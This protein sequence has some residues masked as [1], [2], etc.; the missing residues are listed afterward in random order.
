MDPLDPYGHF[1]YI[2]ECLGQCFSERTAEGKALKRRRLQKGSCPRSPAQIRSFLET[3][4]PARLDSEP[5]DTT[6]ARIHKWI[7]SQAPTSG[8]RRKLLQILRRTTLHPAIVQIFQHERDS[9]IRQTI[10]QAFNKLHV[11]YQKKNNQGR[12]KTTCLRKMNDFLAILVTFRGVPPPAT[13]EDLLVLGDI[14]LQQ[15]TEFCLS[16][17]ITRQILLKCTGFQFYPRL[18]TAVAEVQNF[19][20]SYTALMVKKKATW[21]A[22]VT[23]MDYWKLLQALPDIASLDGPRACD[24]LRNTTLKP[25]ASFLLLEYWLNESAVD[26]MRQHLEK[27]FTGLSAATRW[28]LKSPEH[29]TLFDAVLGPERRAIATRGTWHTQTT[30]QVQS[31]LASCL[32][33][34]ET[35]AQR[36]PEPLDLFTFL[37]TATEDQLSA[38]IIHYAQ[39]RGVHNDWVKS[40]ARSHHAQPPINLMLRFLKGGLRSYLKTTN[41]DVLQARQLLRQIPNE[42]IP[43][44]DDVRREF[45]D[46]EMTRM[47]AVADTPGLRLALTILREV[48]LRISAL[49][50]LRFAHLVDRFY[51]PRQQCKVPE[52]GLAMRVFLTSPKLRQ[53]IQEHLEFC[54]SLHHQDLRDLRDLYIL[55]V[56]N[57][58]QPLKT[59]TMR[60]LIKEVA[61]KAHIDQVLVHPHAFRHTIIGK[62]IQAGNSMELASKF[63]GHRQVSTTRRNYWVPT[64]TALLK[65]MK[66]PFLD[67]YVMPEPEKQQEVEDFNA[68][69]AR[70]ALD[71]LREYNRVLIQPHK[72]PDQIR[73][74]IKAIPKLKEKLEL[75]A[76]ADFSDDDELK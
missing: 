68:L 75:L 76:E 74:E 19:K 24:F 72:T 32:G 33:V 64:T 63:I 10:R 34:M 26:Y 8:T 7:Q 21:K 65:Q 47:M 73:Q 59:A 17:S 4:S 61:R 50:N 44:S 49:C 13:D 28:K 30:L 60:Y 43:L 1:A 29:K 23:F 16:G 35:F 38:V 52:K 70:G 25:R 18:A 12:P 22:A 42:R 45:T 31:A 51:Q 66:N 15:A 37:E 48:G 62:L 2:Q 5:S 36:L 53:A 54:R 14:S 55:N 6:Q 46:A 57:P 56:H 58:R 11:A 41:P 69:R 71:V 67:N 40:R 39:T 3:I 27:Q 9:D 20:K